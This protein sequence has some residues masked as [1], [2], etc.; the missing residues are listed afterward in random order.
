MPEGTP[1]FCTDLSMA[2]LLPTRGRASR[3]ARPC[4]EEAAVTATKS[5]GARVAATAKLKSCLLAEGGL[6]EVVL[7]YGGAVWSYG[8]AWRQEVEALV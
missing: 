8:R 3:P 5:W 4:S 2:P 6:Y 7:V 1:R